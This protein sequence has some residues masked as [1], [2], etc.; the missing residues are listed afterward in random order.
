MILH[1]LF[2]NS[3]AP[4]SRYQQHPKDILGP[5]HFYPPPSLLSHWNQPQQMAARYLLLPLDESFRI[6]ILVKSKKVL[7]EWWLW[8]NLLE[9]F[10]DA[11]ENAIFP[12]I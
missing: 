5:G 1:I 9:P 3:V 6:K 10:R 8:R 4:Y 11:T 2:P 12:E 7:N